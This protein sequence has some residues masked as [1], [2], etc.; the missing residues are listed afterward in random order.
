MT[1]DST[2]ISTGT[3]PSIG[4]LVKDVSTHLSAVVHGEIELAKIELSS[5]VKKLGIGAVLLSIAGV[6]ALFSLFFFFFG[7]A[8]II[9]WAGLWRWAAFAIVFG[10]MLVCAAVAALL[11]I[12]KL[13]KIRPPERTI[14]TTK[15]TVE[16]LTHRGGAG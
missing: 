12:R 15:S 3:D 2:G 10:F 9:A 11:G 1:A 5:S 4:E 13:K 16:A 7:I 6:I 8:E 14:A